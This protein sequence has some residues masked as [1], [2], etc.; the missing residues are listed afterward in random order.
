MLTFKNHV[1]EREKEVHT[2]KAFPSTISAA[3][4]VVVLVFFWVECEEKLER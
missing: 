3:L 4:L 1:A 2:A